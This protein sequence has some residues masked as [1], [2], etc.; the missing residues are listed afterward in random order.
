[1]YKCMA[2]AQNRLSCALVEEVEG[3]LNDI[4]AGKTN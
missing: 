4:R 3:G 2:P 1:M